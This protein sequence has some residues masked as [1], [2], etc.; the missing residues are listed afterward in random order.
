MSAT[1][2]GQSTS[3]ERRSDATARIPGARRSP[4]EAS[5]GAGVASLTQL[6]ILS[7][8]MLRGFFRDR[9]AL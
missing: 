2:S 6:R 4:D 5:R 9:T 7:Q 3:A 8:A 1:A